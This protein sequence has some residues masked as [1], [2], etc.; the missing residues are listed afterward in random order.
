MLV[1]GLIGSD[2]V[3]DEEISSLIYIRIAIE[4]YICS[5]CG[6]QTENFKCVCMCVLVCVR[7]MTKSTK[8]NQRKTTRK[9]SPIGYFQVINV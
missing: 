5:L 2:D 6:I 4:I 9:R 8:E 7:V 1:D 3:D